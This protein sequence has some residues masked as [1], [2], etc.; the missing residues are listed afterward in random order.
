[1]WW[2]IAKPLFS[3]Y[4]YVTWHKAYITFLIFFTDHFCVG[5]YVEAGSK[6]LYRD[7]QK[8]NVFWICLKILIH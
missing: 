7:L 8:K 3:K 2:Q 1:M 5:F 6:I 4:Y